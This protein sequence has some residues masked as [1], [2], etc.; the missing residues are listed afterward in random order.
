[1]GGRVTPAPLTPALMLVLWL[2]VGSCPLPAVLLRRGLV[3]WTPGLRSV[4]LAL[5]KMG[6]GWTA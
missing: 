4:T 3:E 2:V 5:D 6:R 1:M